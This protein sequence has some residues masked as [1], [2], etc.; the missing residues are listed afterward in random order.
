E[1][2]AGEPSAA[3]AA[4]VGAARERQ[5]R[6]YEGRGWSLKS[7]LPGPL[8]RTE[9]AP[10]RAERRLLDHA[11][12]QGRRTLRGHD[13]VLRLAWSL[14]DLDA[15]DRPTAE[16]IG[17]ALTLREGDPRSPARPRLSPTR[18]PTPRTAAPASPGR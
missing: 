16:H 3:I 17:H 14:A 9:F 1:G 15:A 8:L 4:R 2:A 13:R 7:L 5:R 11:V 12:A 18:A 10:H 6:R